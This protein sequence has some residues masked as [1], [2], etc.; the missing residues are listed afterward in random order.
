MIERIERVRERV[1]QFGLDA[2]LI[3]SQTNIRYLFN[4]TGSN[5]IALIAS[6]LCI[7]ITDRRYADQAPLEVS[8]AEIVIARTDLFSELKKITEIRPGLKLG[9]EATHLRLN[10]YHKLKKLLPKV[11][12]MASERIVEN[13]ASIKDEDE[14]S[15]IR[16]A[17]K[18]VQSVFENVVM[19]VKQG[20][21]ELDVSAEISYQCMKDGSERDP[22]EP[23][24]A[25][26]WRSALPHGISSPKKL[27]KG[28]LVIIDFGATVN[29][30]IADF[31]RTVMIGE[32]NSKQKEMIEM[33]TMSLKSAE[34]VAKPG[35]SAKALDMAARSFL[36]DNGY[37]KYFKHSLG[38]GIGLDVHEL[39][40]VGER[41][42]DLLQAGNVITM[43]PGV[44][45]PNL[46]G[47]RIEDDFLITETGVENLT[48]ISRETVCVA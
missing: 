41:S 18:I 19:L 32:P 43:E 14:I 23:I 44:Y 27:E 24:V 30:Y 42:T 4:F 28:D 6:D 29:G 39:P 48:P 38:H 45:I 46:G 15:N 10:E 1:A 2:I 35:L 34:L 47:V 8:N 25:S 36:N 12:L 26:G 22:F 11:K 33:V 3:S 21:S 31:T 40:R 20:L 37:G 9:V 7:L 13:I 5:A 17:A 16:E